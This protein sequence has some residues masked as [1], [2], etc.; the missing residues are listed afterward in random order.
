MLAFQQ[1]AV[2]F[3]LLAL[4]VPIAL[5][6]INRAMAQPWRFPSIRLIPIA[7]LPRTGKR[8]LSDPL[9][10][11]LRL[12][13]YAC[14]IAA[15][16]QP[17]WQGAPDSLAALSTPAR[18]WVFLVDT[19]ASMERDG[20]RERLLEEMDKFEDQLG[21]DD[22]I[23]VLFFDTTAR[24][25]VKPGSPPDALA[26]IGDL[27]QINPFRGEAAPALREALLSMPA[28]GQ[29]DLVLLSDFQASNWSSPSMPTVDPAI[30]LHFS[31]LSPRDPRANLTLLSVRSLPLL[32]NRLR[33][34]ADVLNNSGEEVA[35]TLRVE[36][37]AFNPRQ[38]LVLK[39][40]ERHSV[41]FTI[42]APEEAFPGAMRIESAGDPYA[43]DNTRAFWFG[44]PPV[45]EVFTLLPQTDSPVATDELFF[46]EQA[47][48]AASKDNWLRLSLLPVTEMA[49]NEQT[50]ARSAAIFLPGATVPDAPWPVL[51]NYI[52]KGG[53][54]FVTLGARAL[55]SVKLLQENDLPVAR[56]RGMADRSAAST[57]R[58]FVGPLPRESILQSTF[59]GEA[60]R[61]LFRVQLRQFARLA[62]HP[63]T[64]VLL[65]TESGEPLVLSYRLGEGQL[66]L[67]AFP[68]STSAS[69]LPLRASFLPL[70]RTLLQPA[71]PVNDGITEL[72]PAERPDRP[73]PAAFRE[74]EQRILIN[75]HPD[76]AALSRIPAQE[77]LDTLRAGDPMASESARIATKRERDEDTLFSLVP[78]LLA[79]VMAL[80]FLESLLAAR[81]PLP[82]K[83]AST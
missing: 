2:L 78:W 8:R 3:A 40:G 72:W 58:F 10:L 35:A 17:Q 65:T 60:V 69:D 38:E 21:N 14:L 23:G 75:L 39:P 6:L 46:V 59:S 16:A 83:T 22:Q 36:T 26:D 66:I 27:W 71:T 15:L 30:Q 73:V 13:L 67:S 25:V 61:D 51:R 42:D 48:A 74:A 37:R 44:P 43:L 24:W 52:H 28:S 63:E 80:L 49:F 47:L 55:E 5:H 41:V 79:A 81:L 62:A 9:L 20:V 76:E 68:F 7:P 4:A 57:T 70:L 19:S 45:M 54:V 64:D 18:T 11:L 29:R 31:D 53:L 50:L 12:L 82:R 1:P 32:E 77:L 34:E 33:L 56:Y